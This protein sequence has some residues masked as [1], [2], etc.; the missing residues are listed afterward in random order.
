MAG[1]G[2]VE[3][4]DLDG[5]GE[6]Y[7]PALCM[8]CHGGK[9]TVHPEDPVAFFHAGDN[10]DVKA[11]FLPFDLANFKYSKRRRFTSNAQEGK[12]RRLNQIVKATDPNFAIT[13]LID[14]WYHP[15]GQ[16]K[17]QLNFL[18]PGWK[19]DPAAI[20]PVPSSAPELYLEV[21]KTSCRT[22]H[23]AMGNVMGNAMVPDFDWAQFS[24]FDAF[25]GDI[26]TDICEKR[27]MPQALETFNLFWRSEDPFQVDVLKMA[28]LKGWL[29]N[30]ACPCDGPACKDK[31]G[32]G[33]A[34]NQDNCPNVANRDQTDS[35]GD[36]I[37][38]ACEPDSDRD[39]VADDQDN[40]LNVANPDQT[41]SNGDGIG[42]ACEA[43]IDSDGDGV[44]DNQDNCKN[45]ANPDQA[46][47]DGDRFGNLCDTCKSAANPDQAD[48]DGDR[49]GDACDF[50]EVQ[51]IFNDNCTSC[52]TGSTAERFSLLS[53]VSYDNLVNKASIQAPSMDRVEPKDILKSYLVHKLEN[54]QSTV[55]G[56]G[57]QMPPP[58]TAPLG[59]ITTIKNWIGEGAPK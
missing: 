39:G 11:Q 17:Q 36:G 24:D 37:G 27:I 52:H 57:D 54:T 21:V 15:D 6:K 28:G 33:V 20:P 34:D 43:V 38:D 59:D 47:S 3:E 55:G 35:D 44:A 58:P 29:P 2:Q 45:V 51:K 12:F 53:A 14:G 32:D 46:D 1:L 25:S 4:A 19:E 9:H 30:A 49:I 41:D 42:D 5:R 23:V 7:V 31:D 40:C 18:P 50:S 22:C 56:R 16:G 13:Q 8:A 26:R 48:S 10:P